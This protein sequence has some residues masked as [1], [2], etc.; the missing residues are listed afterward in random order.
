MVPTP[1]TTTGAAAPG[2]LLEV[3]SL[4]CMAG[5]HPLFA[6]WSCRVAPGVTLVQGGEGTGKTTLLRLMAGALAP[7]TG[8]FR[9]GAA[10]LAGQP[11]AYRQQVFLADPNT[12]AFD[13]MSPQAYLASLEPRY[14][15]FDAQ[16]AQGLFEGLSLAEHQHKPMYMLSTGSRRKV[17]FAAA[18][19]SGAALTLL[20][21]PFAAL[22]RRSIGFV[23]EVLQ[24]AALRASR[25]WIMADY[26]APAG[27]ALT[28]VIDLG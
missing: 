11:Q 5:P 10:D 14:P 26:A 9:L 1:A 15:R 13:Q 23:C 24:D 7:S 28:G 2:L 8:T 4:T 16:A 18:A 12:A 19:A 25:I 22:D 17:W 6:D 27:V 3:A 20:D 21:D